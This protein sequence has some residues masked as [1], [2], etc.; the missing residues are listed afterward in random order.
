[1]AAPGLIDAVREAAAQA[2]AGY[3]A[4]D[5]RR[6]VCE[7]G[8]GTDSGILGALAVALAAHA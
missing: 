4:G 8:L 3:F 6:I 5:P 2:G 1:M 7:P